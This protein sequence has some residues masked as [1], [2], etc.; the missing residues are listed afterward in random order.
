VY[1]GVHA[2]GSS[3]WDVPEDVACE[4]PGE[5]RPTYWDWA[6]SPDNPPPGLDTP[7]PPSWFEFGVPPGSPAPPCVTLVSGCASV[8]S[9]CRWT[10]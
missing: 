10:N 7:T 2:F 9:T 3:V 5:I 4:G 1:P 6:G 8:V